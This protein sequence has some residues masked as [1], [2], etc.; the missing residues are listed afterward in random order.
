MLDT[1]PTFNRTFRFYAGSSTNNLIVSR[2]DVLNLLQSAISTG[3]GGRIMGSA[4]VNWIELSV[5]PNGVAQ[6]LS[7]TWLSALGKPKVVNLTTLGTAEVA[8]LRTRPS[9]H[10]TASFY[11]IT[12]SSES[13]PLV[14]LDI[15]ANAILDVNISFTF[16]NYI[17]N[18]TVPVVTTS[19]KTLVPSIMYCAA[20]D[21]VSTNVLIPLG[22]LQF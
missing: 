21:G 13:E 3:S 18:A 5:P 7:M 19:T 2:G 20:F 9:E 1:N 10:T 4:K 12:G 11:S 17:N 8:R 22:I 6:T 15:P 14:G 16:N